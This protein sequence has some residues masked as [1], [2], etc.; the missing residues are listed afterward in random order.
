MNKS[1]FLFLIILRTVSTAHAQSTLTLQDYMGQVEQLSPGIKGAKL[2]EE[3]SSE[4]C[5]RSQPLLC[6]KNFFQV[7]TIYMTNVP[8]LFLYFREI[9]QSP[10][11]FGGLKKT[12]RFRDDRICFLQY[13]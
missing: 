1:L 3:A 13:Q 5:K 9:K 11:I 7:T 12:N 4:P 8:H 6:S 10:I 2:Q